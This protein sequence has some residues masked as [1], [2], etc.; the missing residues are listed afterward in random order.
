MEISIAEEILNIPLLNIILQIA[1]YRRGYPQRM[2]ATQ[3]GLKGKS[4]FVK[5]KVKLAARHIPPIMTTGKVDKISD[6]FLSIFALLLL[7]PVLR[8]QLISG[9]V[10]SALFVFRQQLSSFFNIS[11]LPVL[12][13]QLISLFFS[14]IISLNIN[15]LQAG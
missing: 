11:S 10:V 15:A 8:Q 7:L 4:V 1:V 6:N 2:T 13:Q 9:C 12:R 14:I 3:A 5:C